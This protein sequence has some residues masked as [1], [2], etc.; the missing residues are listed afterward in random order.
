[1]KTT[2]PLRLYIS[3]LRVTIAPPRV[4]TGP[5]RVYI[6]PNIVLKNISPVPT[7]PHKISVPSYLQY[8]VPKSKSNRN[9]PLLRYVSQHA[10][11]LNTEKALNIFSHPSVNHFYTKD[12][13]K[14][15]LD[16]LLH[17]PNKDIWEK[18]LS[19]ELGRA[20]FVCDFRPLKSDPWRIR[21][22]AG[23]DKLCFDGD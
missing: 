18:A 14:E 11:T 9:P 22:M 19:N 20:A 10:E 1:M 8:N 13:K 5:P 23:G 2:A 17:G 12:G 6:I 21:C 7:P 3:P 16:S 4:Q 15:I